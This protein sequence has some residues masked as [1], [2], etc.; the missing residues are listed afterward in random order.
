MP[1]KKGVLPLLLGLFV[2]LRLGEASGT[3]PGWARSYLDDALCLPLVLT[4]VLAVHRLGSRDPRWCLPLSH[5]LLALGLY[6]LLFEVLLPRIGGSAVA[7]PVDLVM[8]A[9]GLAFFQLLINRPGCGSIQ[10]CRSSGLDNE[11]PACA[12]HQ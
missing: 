6:G 4:G 8:Y 11:F 9:A 10:S 3:A 5:G 2:L 1:G 7:D 12:D